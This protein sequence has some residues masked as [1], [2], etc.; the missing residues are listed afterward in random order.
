M[1]DSPLLKIPLLAVSQA[2]KETTIN[3]AISYL[4][5]AM[6]DAIT[7]NFAGGTVNLPETDLLRYFLFRVTAIGAASTLNIVAK[8][9]LFVVDNLPNAYTVNVSCG[10]GSLTVPIGGIVVIYCDGV[11][12]ISVADSTIMGAGGSSPSTF[13]TLLDTPTSYAGLEGQS[14]V[15]NPD[16]DGLYGLPFKITGLLDVDAT[17]LADNYTLKWNVAAQKW[18]VAPAGSGGS[19]G[20][21]AN[22]LAA[23]N[24]ATTLPL[25]VNDDI[26]IGSEVDGIILALGDRVLVKNQ[27]ALTQ[28]GIWEV[29]SGAPV[30]PADAADPGSY[31]QG[32]LIPT[33]SGIT[34]GLKIFIQMEPPITSDPITPGI[35]PLTFMTNAMS[36]GDLKDVNDTVLANGNTLVY[37]DATEMWEAKALQTLPVGG[38][39]GQILRK[40]S[41]TEGDASWAD[42]SGGVKKEIAFF[43]AGKGRNAEILCAYTSS[44]AFTI[45]EVDSLAK[46]MV[47][48]TSSTIYTLK[49][50]AVT[51]G[52]VTFA[53]GATV[54][55]IDFTSPGAI[56]L[57]GVFV[58]E[59]PLVADATLA[60]FY[61]T[62]RE[63]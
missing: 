21:V 29:T 2:A 39:V 45:S 5:R 42:P 63:A 37:N 9:R 13:I 36:V 51:V 41:A 38:T 7:L 54:G 61:M 32:S 60:D 46:T 18:I 19:G 31:L 16:E 26:V 53:G 25:T 3:T 10:T 35:N 28:N 22:I 49:I 43:A 40:N 59:G 57:G 17:G 58:V 4:E 15:V 6:N 50:N 14:M 55:V 44:S 33:L 52:T 56:P 12:L 30:R 48:A 34:N 24:V 1:A 8:K 23:V 47:A 20:S 11:N 62:F 27:V